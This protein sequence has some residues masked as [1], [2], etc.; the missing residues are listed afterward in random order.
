MSRLGWRWRDCR[1][2]EDRRCT[3]DVNVFCFR[4]TLAINKREKGRGHIPSFQ[5]PSPC[6]HVII[7]AVVVV[8]SL[9]RTHFRI[10]LY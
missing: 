2:R 6:L 3:R 1:E 5:C 8:A 7:I 10:D 9:V 4:S